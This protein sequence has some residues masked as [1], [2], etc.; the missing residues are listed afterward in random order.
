MPA[1]YQMSGR[2]LKEIAGLQ[3]QLNSRGQL[4]VRLLQSGSVPHRLTGT[5]VDP[6]I[7]DQRR[8]ISQVVRV[9][10]VEDGRG[11]LGPVAIAPFPILAH[12]TGRA[13]LSHPALRLASPKAHSGAGRGRRSRHSTSRF[14]WISSKV[15]SRVPRPATLCRLSRLRLRLAVELS[16]KVPDLIWCYWAHRQS[17]SPRH[18]R[19]RTRS[20][21]PLLRRH[22]PASTLQ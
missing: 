20:Q 10:R 7:P 15:N 21:G 4:G 17:P 12:R 8:C 11:S 5:T 2:S 14:R 13:E 18:L 19:K 3:R 9:G 1:K 16:L 22:Y 6:Q